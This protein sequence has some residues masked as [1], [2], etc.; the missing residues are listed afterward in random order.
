[1][2]VRKK[3]PHRRLLMCFKNFI[4]SFVLTT[5]TTLIAKEAAPR[6]PASTIVV[7][8]TMPKDLVSNARYYGGAIPG[9]ILGFGIGHAI[10][11]RYKEK[12]WIFT[13]LE[14]G[15]V[16][17]FFLT[18]YLVYIFSPRGALGAYAISF[19]STIGLYGGVLRAL[20]CGK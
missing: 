10:Q 6:E 18:N 9:S 8:K 16:G 4:A 14:G 15:A 11:G 3:R 1:M 5:A 2:L 17:G 20:K 12:G 7:E 19:F 13:L